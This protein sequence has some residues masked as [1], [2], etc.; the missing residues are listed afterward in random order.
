MCGTAATFHRCC[1]VRH[2]S[3]CLRYSS[4]RRSG[5]GVGV[6]GAARVLLA[7]VL[8]TAIDILLQ[9]R[10]P[11][12]GKDSGDLADGAPDTFIAVT[13]TWLM[14]LMSPLPLRQR[15]HV[16]GVVRDLGPIDAWLRDAGALS[17]TPACVLPLL[18][19]VVSRSRACTT[20]GPRG[21]PS[22]IPLGA[23]PAH[24]DSGPAAVENGKINTGGRHDGPAR[25]RRRRPRVDPSIPMSARWCLRREPLPLRRRC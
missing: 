23:R 5:C 11:T 2:L 15:W 16:Y 1:A 3:R 14:G 9:A 25:C 10:I 7:M 18:I 24:S 13:F 8:I 4:R 12:R 17:A 21:A 20:A 22:L 6:P 19:G